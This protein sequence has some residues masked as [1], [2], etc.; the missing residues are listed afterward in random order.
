MK[1]AISRRRPETAAAYIVDQLPQ[2]RR[3][4]PRRPRPGSSPITSGSMVT[5][6]MTRSNTAVSTDALAPKC[7]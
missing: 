2:S 5:A 1:T 4:C 3:R 6:S 7:R